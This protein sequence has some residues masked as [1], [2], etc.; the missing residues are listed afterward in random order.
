MSKTILTLK[1]FYYKEIE[2]SVPRSLTNGKSSEDIADLLLDWHDDA[3]NAEEIDKRFDE[4]S[5]ENL[6]CVT[7]LDGKGVLHEDTD[8]YDMYN[9]DG[10]QIYGGHL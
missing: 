2:I 9:D 8:R 6:E 1:R 7:G 5:Y 3:P 10:Q 4:A